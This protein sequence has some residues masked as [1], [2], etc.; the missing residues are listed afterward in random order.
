MEVEAAACTGLDVDM[1][2]MEAVETVAVLIQWLQVLGTSWTHGNESFS[3]S[4]V[5]MRVVFLHYYIGN[6]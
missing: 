4:S 5:S 1:H 6:W 3:S 2:W